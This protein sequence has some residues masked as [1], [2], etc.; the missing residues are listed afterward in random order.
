MRMSLLIE[1][2]REWY[3][4]CA[5]GLWIVVDPKDRGISPAAC[6]TISRLYYYCIRFISSQY[7]QYTETLYSRRHHRMIPIKGEGY[8]PT[9][10][11][12]RWCN[13]FSI[14]IHSMP[15]IRY[16]SI[17]LNATKQ[18]FDTLDRYYNRWSVSFIQ[19]WWW[20]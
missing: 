1:L 16:I 7:N 10:C 8:T 20:W 6:V 15:N 11:S 9:S 4:L 13:L 14:I 19:L 2:T 12:R 17:S 3:A 5:R 18:P